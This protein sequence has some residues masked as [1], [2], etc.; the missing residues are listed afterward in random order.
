MDE[1]FLL[2]NIVGDLKKNLYIF[3]E[4]VR[5]LTKAAFPYARDDED[6]MKAIKR[7]NKILGHKELS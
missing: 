5:M 3:A 6:L 2:I 1:K 7:I 4:A